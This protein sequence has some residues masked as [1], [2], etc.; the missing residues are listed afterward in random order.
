MERCPYCF[1]QI[2]E[3]ERCSCGYELS[4]NANIEEALRPGTIIGACYQIGAVLGKGGFGITYRGYDLNMQ[5]IV[6]IKEFFP[7]GLVF[8]NGQVTGIAPVRSN[9]YNE[10]RT[11][12]GSK[13]NVFQKSLDLFYREAVA[14]GKLSKLPNVV[15]AYHVFR[16]NNTA[17][18][19]MEFVE[20]RSLKTILRER[21]RIPEDE[22]LDLLDPILS[23]L[24]NLL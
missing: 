6:A 1:K 8:R 24:E 21:T 14:L 5:K 3:G 7:D 18:I 20:G 13:S 23:V 19:V 11:V 17:Y 16:E 22:L 9:T 12:S 2:A 10:V 4:D 15:H